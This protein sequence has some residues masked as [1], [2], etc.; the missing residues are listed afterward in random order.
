[1]SV[2]DVSPLP[3][4]L[5]SGMVLMP[6]GAGQWTNTAARSDD[7]L[8]VGH[9]RNVRPSRTYVNDV[10]YVRA[11]VDIGRMMDKSTGEALTALKARAGLSLDAIAKAAG[12]RGR[13]SVQSFFSTS[14]NKPLDTAVAIKLA[15][16][17]EGRGDPPIERSEVLIL[18]GAME[19]NATV[20]RYEGASAVQ[21]PRDV[22]I[23]GTS[24]GAPRDFDGIAIEQTMLNSG[25][26]IGY[27]PR[28]TVLNGQKSAYGLYVQGSSMAP[29][30]EDG[31]TIFV[32]DSRQ[33]RPPRIGEDVVVYLRD[34][35]CDDG[36]TA[37]AVL[38][39]RLVRR[40]AEYTELE[41]FNPALTFRLPAD[42]ILRIDRVIPWA[43]LLS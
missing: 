6:K 19:S 20:L 17:L 33:S 14:Y 36:E 2:R 26:V 5:N 31:E 16:A 23:F 35:E 7:L 21:L 15:D 11:S 37:T 13:S 29:R 28:P 39:K 22:P 8:V 3:P 42:R 30:H 18:T 43:E 32:Q 38:V 1:M 12:Y 10:D 9:V 27:L 41:Q 4:A 34:M 40:T 25:G 24:L